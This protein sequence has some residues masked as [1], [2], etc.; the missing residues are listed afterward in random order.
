MPD[1]PSQPV[2]HHFVPQFMLRYF[3]DGGERL[4]VHR[5]ADQRSFRSKVRDVGHRNDGHTLYSFRTGEPDRT[6]L[7]QSMGEIEGAAATVIRHLVDG[8]DLDEE[9]RDIL[10]WFMSLQ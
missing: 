1:V 7:E 3:A 4:V 2:K 8:A 10:S 5:I 9:S 6:W